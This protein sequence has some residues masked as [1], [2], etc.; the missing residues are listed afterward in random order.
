MRNLRVA[1]LGYQAKEET[2]T[3][4][5]PQSCA[6]MLSKACGRTL[7]VLSLT[8]GHYWEAEPIYAPL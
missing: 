2:Y 4:Y 8:L 6:T 7:E 1:K 5:H 3:E